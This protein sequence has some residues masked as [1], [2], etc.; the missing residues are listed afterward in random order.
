MRITQAHHDNI[1]SAGLEALALN[2]TEHFKTAVNAFEDTLHAAHAIYHE[3]GILVPQIRL[4][5]L[6]ERDVEP[7]TFIDVL[8]GELNRVFGTSHRYSM[9]VD[10]KC[11][12]ML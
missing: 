8:E 10:A 6:F 9:R 2:S 5:G 1:I 7:D 4:Y 3:R 12:M 11:C